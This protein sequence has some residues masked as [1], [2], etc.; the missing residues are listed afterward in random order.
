[1]NQKPATKSIKK[2]SF[3]KRHSKYNTDNNVHTPPLFKNQIF[4]NVEASVSAEGER[5]LMFIVK[6]RLKGRA[7]VII[8][9]WR[10]Q[11]GQTRLPLGFV[12]I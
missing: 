7:G 10:M 11:V 9:R 1:L 2:L 3:T 12:K 4:T 6:T 5:V 8:G